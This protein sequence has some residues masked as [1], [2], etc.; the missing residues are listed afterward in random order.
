MSQDNSNE[1]L[2][3]S[4]APDLQGLLPQAKSWAVAWTVAHGERNL[5]QY[6]SARQVPCFLPK[7][8]RRRVYKSGIKS[9]FLPLFPGYVF[10]DSAAIDRHE[11]F[12]SRKVADIVHPP[13]HATLDNELSQIALAISRDS[14]LRECRLGPPGRPVYVARGPMKGLAGELVRIGPQTRL[15]LRITFLSKVAELAIDEAYVEPLL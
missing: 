3:S 1:S 7:I 8:F 15:V 9:W 11:V 6:F 5:E 13:D 14:G 4:S 10:F 2:S 12:Q